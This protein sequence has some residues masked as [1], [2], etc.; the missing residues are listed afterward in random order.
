MD[1]AAHAVGVG[2]V[3]REIVAVVLQR[4]AAVAEILLRGHAEI[5][6]RLREL[7]VEA[8]RL[9]ER[10]VR[11]AEVPE[12][13]PRQSQAVPDVGV[14]GIEAQDVSERGLRLRELA[15]K[16]HGLSQTAPDPGVPRVLGGSGEE[17]AE[18]V[19]GFPSVAEIEMQFAE[20]VLN[21]REIAVE[22]ERAQVGLLRVGEP[23]G[24]MVRESEMVPRAGVRRQFCR[25]QF[26][27]SHRFRGVS[28]LQ[29]P[30]AAQ[31]R[32]GTGRLATRQQE[33]DR[34]ACREPGSRSGPG[35]GDDRSSIVRD[36]HWKRS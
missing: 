3:Q 35:G 16:V 11:F 7:R 28:G 14:I 33:G 9:A 26:E 8:R 18:R 36:V 10:Q 12:L 19:L 27:E 20:I 30:V 22:V 24:R 1:V 5:E 15:L 34:R 2:R 32:L 6:V 23:A 29:F 25:R 21:L 13:D 17:G 31:Q 4:G